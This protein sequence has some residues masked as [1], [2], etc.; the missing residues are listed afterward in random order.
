MDRCRK[1]VVC[2]LGSVDVVIGMHR[3]MTA[4]RFASLSGNQ[5][6]DHLVHVHVRLGS[7]ARL[8]DAE[9]ELVVVLT[10]GDG[11]GGLRNR[12]CP[13]WVENL[14]L[15]VDHSTGL[16]DLC[17]RMDQLCR[18]AFITDRE[19]PKGALGLGAPERVGRNT[20]GPQ[21]V[22]LLSNPIFHRRMPPQT[23]NRMQPG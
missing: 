20:D 5:V 2:R 4:Q 21:A 23:L 7:T 22:P 19:I 14:H 6:A 1:D 13:G 11:F 12:V 17:Q 16:F 9:R 15:G 10:A 18:H 8:P 3:G